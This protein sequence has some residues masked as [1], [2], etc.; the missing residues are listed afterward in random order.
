MIQITF[1]RMDP[2]IMT[3]EVAGMI[4]QP[5]WFPDYLGR[6]LVTH[7]METAPD[8]LCYVEIEDVINPPRYDGHPLTNNDGY[9]VMR[10][11]GAGDW[12]MIAPSLKKLKEMYGCRIVASS[13]PRFKPI[14]DM[15]PYVD[16]WIVPP[17]T[18]EMQEGITAWTTF[19]KAIEA[20]THDA[21]TLN[22]ID[23]FSKLCCVNLED[24]EKIPSIRIPRV[25]NDRVSAFIKKCARRKK[26]V[27]IQ[28]KTSNI[29]RTPPMM[30]EVIARLAEHGKV[31]VMIVG[32]THSVRDKETGK[33]IIGEDGRV[34]TAPDCDVVF[35]KGG[36]NGKAHPNI[37]NLCGMLQWKDTAAL[38]AQSDLVVSG[39][40][41]AIHLSAATD[42][43]CLGLYGPFPGDL[44]ARYYPKCM[45]IESTYECA[46]CFAHGRKPCSRFEKSTNSAPCWSTMS[47]EE[48]ADTA[49]KMLGV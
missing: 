19:E 20:P 9:F 42:T 17:I 2:V 33:P 37:S 41:A 34:K 35:L 16:S 14:I 49:L 22:G 40:S 15:M 43:P 12:L 5:L 3:D 8:K 18:P 1:T 46:P 23:L 7:L 32:G 45:T 27:T 21:H 47:A 28:Y 26:I 10:Q 24:S 31:H 29:N 11:G 13:S 25:S 39:D 30:N 44:R 48:I 4:G 6:G 38:I 36:V